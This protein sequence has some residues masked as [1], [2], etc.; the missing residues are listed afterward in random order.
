MITILRP[1]SPLQKRLRP[2]H[3]AAFGQG[4]GFWVPVEKLFMNEI[5]FDA[6]SV[7]LMAAAS[8]RV[9]RCGG[10]RSS[11]TPRWPPTTPTV[12]AAVGEPDRLLVRVQPGLL[13]YSVQVGPAGVPN[14]EP[15]TGHHARAVIAT[16]QAH[17][18]PA[19]RTHGV[20]AAA[21]P[22]VER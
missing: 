2:L 6:A 12:D 18:V 11:P 17:L 5:G 16:M 3:L 22:Q 14:A 13:R 10:W 21:W 7:G 15:P 19:W 20:K 1:A 9:R 8:T 4:I